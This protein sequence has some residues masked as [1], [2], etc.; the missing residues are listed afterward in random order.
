MTS[1]YSYSYSSSNSVLSAQCSVLSAQCSVLS[2]QQ[3]TIRTAV[4]FVRTA[5]LHPSR[6][7]FPLRRCDCQESTP[8]PFMR[9]DS[10]KQGPQ[11]EW[12]PALTE[13]HSGQCANHGPK[14]HHG[15]ISRIAWADGLSVSNSNP[16]SVAATQWYCHRRDGR[17]RSSTS[18]CNCNGW[19]RSGPGSCS[20]RFD[21]G[22]P[23][24][25][26][27]R[28]GRRCQ[29]SSLAAWCRC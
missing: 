1:N 12:H 6:V 3:P 18:R 5:A 9:Q 22:R 20:C 29:S 4:P 10:Q 24:S 2:A 7:P 15:L 14:K 27:R 23:S 17:R 25:S 28:P 8:D 21:T 16:S 19:G 26:G 13:C 11:N